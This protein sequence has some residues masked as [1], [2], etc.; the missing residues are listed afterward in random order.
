MRHVPWLL[1]LIVAAAAWPALPAAAPG[2]PPVP[3][4]FRAAEGA[5]FGAL[6]D[7]GATAVKLVV[8]WSEIETRQGTWQWGALDDAVSAAVSAGLR[9]ILVLSYTPKWASQASGAELL[10]PGIYAR[11]PAK[12]LADW[13]AFV[14]ATSSRFRDRVRDWQIW[15]ARSLPL[16]RGTTREYVELLRSARVVI[17]AAGPAGQAAGRGESVPH[18]L[19]RLGRRGDGLHTDRSGH[20]GDTDRPPAICRIPHPAACPAVGLR[21]H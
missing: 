4:G 9:V 5:D 20:A 8:N 3:V 13:E 17:K 18:R 14:T 16:F 21:R 2:A 7:A 15:T 6:R 12:Q 10:D 11:Q 19:R 1:A